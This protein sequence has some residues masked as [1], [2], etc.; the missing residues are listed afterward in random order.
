[1]TTE[2][3]HDAVN[4]KLVIEYDGKNYSGWQRQ[5]KEAS[6]QQKIEDSLK[7]L[8]PGEKVTITGAGRTD[9]GVHAYGQCANFKVNKKKFK[10]FGINKLVHSLNAL[11]PDDILIKKLSIVP[12][13]FNSR[14]SAKS[15]EYIYRF[16]T[17]KKA[18]DR[19]GL[20]HIKYDIDLDKAKEFCKVIEGAHSFKTLCKNKTDDHD[21]YC[22]IVYARVS[23]KTGGIYE[24]KIAANRFLHSMV[25][26]LTGA[27][28][29]VSSGKMSITEFTQKFKKGDEIKIQ[30]VPSNALFLL[31]VNY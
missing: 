15:R 8:F 13:S 6:I 9:A 31:K 10:T 7:I 17:V 24:F 2:T 20:Y 26:A 22:N 28:L 27:M 23:K 5:K 4:L 1:L 14:Y 16:T 3:D 18:I 29:L 21:F 12:L 25:R 11:L 19:E 30:Y